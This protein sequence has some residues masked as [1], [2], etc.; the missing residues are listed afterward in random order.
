MR[1]LIVTTFVT[2]DGVMQAP[3]GDNEDTD[4]GFQYGGWSVPY[5]DEVMMEIQGINMAPPFDFLIGRKT[6]DIFAAFWP[7]AAPEEGAEVMNAMTK[8][9]ASRHD[10]NL[11]WENSQLLEGDL[12]EAVRAL[13]EQEG[14]DIQVHGSQNMIQTLLA[15]DLIDEFRVWTFPVVVGEGKRL[16]GDGTLPRS[17]TLTDSKASATGVIISTYTLDGELQTG[18]FA[19]E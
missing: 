1:K 16:F 15:N 3:G 17:L 2:L 12:V 6:Y 13:K 4:A 11:E 19:H 7:H 5:W 9:V 8:Y 10:P 14:P 18:T